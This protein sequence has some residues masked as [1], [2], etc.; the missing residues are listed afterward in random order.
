MLRA[1]TSVWA[2]CKT[3]VMALLRGIGG[4]ACPVG[5]GGSAC[6]AGSSN[7]YKACPAGPGIGGSACLDRLLATVRGATCRAFGGLA[8]LNT[9][10]ALRV[11]P[12]GVGVLAVRWGAAL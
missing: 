11:A 7:A 5:I 9:L 10:A 1:L 4:N 8:T 12:V 2:L 6:P 3:K